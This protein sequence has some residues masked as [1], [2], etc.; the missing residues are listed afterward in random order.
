M[1]RRVN[2]YQHRE[3]DR[4]AQLPGAPSKVISARS[5]M[6]QKAPMGAQIELQVL[7]AI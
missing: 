4:T 1:C 6:S 2:G 5:R 7:K 3:E